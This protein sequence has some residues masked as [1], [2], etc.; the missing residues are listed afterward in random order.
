VGSDSNQPPPPQACQKGAHLA[1]QRG[2]H[3]HGLPVAVDH[4]ARPRAEDL[5]HPR[6]GQTLLLQSLLHVGPT[7][8]R[9]PK[10]L[11]LSAPAE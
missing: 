1:L 8:L 10:G 4:E 5:Q 3:V 2:P 9:G 11:L 7:P 6:P